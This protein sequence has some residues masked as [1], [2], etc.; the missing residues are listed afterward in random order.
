MQL[1]RKPTKEEYINFW[2]ETHGGL[3][4]TDL[5]KNKESGELYVLMGSGKWG[6]S[7]EVFLP[8]H[9]SF[10]TLSDVAIIEKDVDNKLITSE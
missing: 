7:V 3:S 2:L 5:K 6:V 1:S 4:W 10:S 8:I 9:H